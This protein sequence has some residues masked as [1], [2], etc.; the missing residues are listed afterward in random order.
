MFYLPEVILY[1][2]E[3]CVF[4]RVTC[5][6]IARIVL[7]IPMTCTTLAFDRLVSFIDTIIRMGIYPF[8]TFCFTYQNHD[9]IFAFLLLL[10]MHI[11]VFY[12]YMLDIV[13][14][15]EQVYMIVEMETSGF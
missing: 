11:F 2:F 1:S 6:D 3:W 15:L 14:R 8:Y 4:D 9:D 5:N 12:L 13:T 10:K 7:T